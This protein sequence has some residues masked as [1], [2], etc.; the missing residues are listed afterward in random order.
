MTIDCVG[1]PATVGLKAISEKERP[2]GK[3]VTEEE[4]FDGVRE[5]R[6]PSG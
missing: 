6:N 3:R 4:G 1:E 2:K 5:K